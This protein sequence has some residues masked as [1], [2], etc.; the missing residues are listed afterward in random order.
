MLKGIVMKKKPMLKDP[1]VKMRKSLKLISCL[2]V[3]IVLIADSAQGQESNK[4]YAYNTS[5]ILRCDSDLSNQEILYSGYC[6]FIDMAAGSDAL[7]FVDGSGTIYRTKLNGD[8]Y[9]NSEGD[10]YKVGNGIQTVAVGTDGGVYAYSSGGSIIRWDSDLTN[11][12]VY[13]KGYGVWVDM[14]ASS[15]SLYFVDGYGIYRTKLD[16][17][18]DSA[19]DKWYVDGIGTTIVAVNGD[20]YVYAS[21]GTHIMRFD[22]DLSNM[23]VFSEV[24]DMYYGGFVDM[25]ASP[26]ALYFAIGAG[27]IFR[28]E[29]DGTDSTSSSGSGVCIVAFPKAPP[30]PVLPG[31]ANGDGM[32]DVGDLGIL[33]ANYGGTNKTWVQGDFNGDTKVDVGDLGILAAHYGEGS[34]QPTNFS[35]DYAKAFGMTT[36]DSNEETEGNEKSDP[37][38]SGLGLPLIVGLVF[39]GITLLKLQRNNTVG[40]LVLFFGLFCTSQASAYDGTF[41]KI[42]DWAVG[43]QWRGVEAGLNCEGF[44]VNNESI[45]PISWTEESLYWNNWAVNRMYKTLLDSNRPVGIM[46][47]DKEN[48]LTG[49]LDPMTLAKTMNFLCGRTNGRL[50]YVFMDFEPNYTTGVIAS[51]KEVVRQVRAHVDSR[52]NQAFCGNYDDFKCTS[53]AW[54]PYPAPNLASTISNAY[55]EAGLNVSMPALYPWSMYMDHANRDRWGS[56]YTYYNSWWDELWKKNP[57]TGYATPELISPSERSALFWAPLEKLSQAKKALPEGH[58]LI[59]WI[60][61]YWQSTSQFVTTAPTKEDN[62]A[63]LMHYRLRGVD[64][65]YVF[66]T[67]S[68]GVSPE[69]TNAEYRSDMLDVWESLNWLFDG[70]DKAGMH[71]LNLE[72]NKSS[73]FEWSS[74]QTNKG[75]AVILSNLGSSG[76]T[77]S[78]QTLVN[79]G[80]NPAYINVL[81]NGQDHIYVGSSQH[82]LCS[83]NATPVV[84]P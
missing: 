75:V 58:E 82:L 8:G 72:T 42:F 7:Y 10:W 65:Y 30:V 12:V 21:D 76:T 6:G 77:F 70:V 80:M 64:G 36:T 84:L 59:P 79:A 14:A 45:T 38:C 5:Q 19:W 34:T 18:H 37:L 55:T 67:G 4:L 73:G 69:Y 31:D 48:P 49:T 35:D 41:P 54:E 63:S 40:M 56:P 29:L 60:N 9:V 44:D 24:Y 20:G 78:F 26:D 47:R 33:A 43:P 39:M 83:S 62:A 3:T 11:G 57:Q 50:N 32:V 52:I 28:T 17:T 15:D 1:F 23:V 46:L 66:I 16:G 51:A 68:D 27:G 13:S 25:A 81:N 22:S 74:V 61:N 53:T 71:I 2:F